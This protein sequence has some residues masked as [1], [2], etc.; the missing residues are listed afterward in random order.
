MTK[1]QPPQTPRSEESD[2]AAGFLETVLPGGGVLRLEFQSHRP[3]ASQGRVTL[4]LLHEGLGCV[5]MWGSFPKRLATHTGC[6][7]FVYSRK[8]YGGSDP[9]GPPRSVDFMHRE[10]WRDLRAV[11]DT[12]QF[13]RFVLVGHS[14]G[15][16]IAA[17]YA[18]SPLVRHPGLRGVVLIAAHVFNERRCIDGIEQAAAAYASGTLR[19]ALRRHHGERVDEVFSRWRD[20]WFDPAFSGWNIESY[21]AQIHHRVLAIQGRDDAYGTLAQLDAIV[22][23]AQGAVHRCVLDACGHSPHRDQPRKTCDAIADFVSDLGPD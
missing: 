14:D 13:D 12:A 22:C 5:G 19:D 4:I 10:A 3:T 6:P 21:L 23:R 11:I 18:G 20:I 17:I 2:L 8:G 1:R 16:S 15:G 9:E 7:V